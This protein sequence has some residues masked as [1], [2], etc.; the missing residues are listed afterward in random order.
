MIQPEQPLALPDNTKVRFVLVPESEA[1]LVAESTVLPKPRRVTREELDALIRQYGVSVGTL[2][3]PNDRDDELTETEPLRNGVLTERPSAP[4]ISSEEF[5]ERIRKYSFS[6]P[7]LPAD[8]SRED[9]YSDH[10]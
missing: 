9:I 3:L 6:A 10:D 8:F 2:P 4:R 5:K 1:Q 7:S